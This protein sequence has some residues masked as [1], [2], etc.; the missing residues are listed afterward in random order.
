MKRI[1]R[2]R[3]R[4][5]H[6][7]NNQQQNKD[8]L[9]RCL[10]YFHLFHFSGRWT[11][12]RTRDAMMT[13]GRRCRSGSDKQLPGSCRRLES[14]NKSANRHANVGFPTEPIGRLDPRVVNPC[15]EWKITLNQ[16]NTGF[17]ERKG[18][19]LVLRVGIGWKTKI[20]QA[21]YRDYVNSCLR[22]PNSRLALP[23]AERSRFSN[24]S[25]LCKPIAR[26]VRQ[27]TERTLKIGIEVAQQ[28][29]SESFEVRG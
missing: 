13:S 7:H 5:K 9:I 11:G 26:P 10:K 23:D 22:S 25:W 17:E 8:F 14:G 18:F 2:Q 28:E 16:K 24:S 3:R 4:Q 21:S 1:R 27:P 12:A 15:C 29:T 20:I 6:T 19:G